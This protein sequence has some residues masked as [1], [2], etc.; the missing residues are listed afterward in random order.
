MLQPSRR[1]LPSRPLV[2]EGLAFRLA[3]WG[4]IPSCRQPPEWLLQW[5][6]NSNGA[7]LAEG[8]VQAFS[9]LGDPIPD[10]T[11]VDLQRL[12][13]HPRAKE[14]ASRAAQALAYCGPT[15]LPT[16]IQALTNKH[17]PARFS[18]LAA[19]AHIA[20]GS[21]SAADLAMPVLL[22]TAKDDDQ[23]PAAEADLVL[24]RIVSRLPFV[25]ISLLS[26]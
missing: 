2:E 26:L 11:R 9:V 18:A 8:A 16:L 12:L 21:E 6:Y 5:L 14:G 15:A 7:A 25:R 3:R 1:S 24:S 4:L 17:S 22:Q 19:I 13:H 20:E 10:K 23:S